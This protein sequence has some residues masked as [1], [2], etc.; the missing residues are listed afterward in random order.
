MKRGQ[1][2]APLLI[3]ICLQFSCGNILLSLS[4]WSLLRRY[5]TMPFAIRNATMAVLVVTTVPALPKIPMIWISIYLKRIGVVRCVVARVFH[6]WLS[7]Q[8][9]LTTNI[10]LFPFIAMRISHTTVVTKCFLLKKG[11]IILL[12]KQ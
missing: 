7:I 8:P 4:I 5:I 10:F 6:V 2:L 9:L 11:P 3:L 12:L 1:N